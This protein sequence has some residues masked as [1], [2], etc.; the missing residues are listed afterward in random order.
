MSKVCIICGSINFKIKSENFCSMH[1][2]HLHGLIKARNTK[3]KC[4]LCNKE[5]KGSNYKKHLKTHDKE[6]KQYHYFCE[7]CVKEVFK[8]Y[9]SARFCSKECA[10][11][12]STKNNRK[13]IG[14]KIRKALTKEPYKKIC[15]TCNNAFETKFKNKKYCSIECSKAYHKS[16]EYLKKLSN[17]L[18]GKTGG[19]KIN[20]GRGK[21]GWYKGYWCQSTYELAWV[22]YHLDK[23]IKFTRNNNIFFKYIFNKKER[24][25]YPDFKIGNDYYEIKGWNDSQT[26][27]KLSQ[28]PKEIKL[29]VL[30]HDDLKEIFNFVEKKY[31]KNYIELYE[32]NPH[33]INRNICKICG[34]EC[35][36][37]Y[38]S[39][40]CSGKGACI[41]NK[42]TKML[43]K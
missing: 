9:G 7:Y 5:I 27:E 22:I 4:K 19:Y 40:Q 20:S 41:R 10:K 11:G 3:I 42:N 2:I 13:E 29:I 12:F 36:N 1:C 16:P 6:Q 23:N 15:K 33:K 43:R 18:K 28:F 8:K 32:G 26:K 38:C 17:S 24:K 14:E 30:F 34:N 39:R 21:C 31:G 25:F 37:E 35:Y